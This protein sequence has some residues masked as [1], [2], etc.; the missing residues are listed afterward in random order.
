VDTAQGISMLGSDDANP[1][2]RL[3]DILIQNN[4]FQNL[5][6]E[7]FNAV[8]ANKQISV[9][10]LFY[11][12]SGVNSGSKN[13]KIDH[14]TWHSPQANTGIGM[15]SYTQTGF[16]FTNNIAP[17]GRYGVYFDGQG[18]GLAH[19]KG[20]LPGG[21]VSH[22]VIWQSNGGNPVPALYWGSQDLNYYPA[23]ASAVGFVDQAKG[24]FALTTSSPYRK[25]GL[26]GTDPGAFP[27][28]ATL[29]KSEER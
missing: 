24:N 4:L 8:D 15:I 5:G 26:E 12:G 25:R 6:N 29:G 19:A 18:D 2:G 14:N 1:S 13:V 11:L 23:R 10:R 28:R 20:W 21:V 22:N 16:V 3:E 9:F 7:H 17:F 27:R